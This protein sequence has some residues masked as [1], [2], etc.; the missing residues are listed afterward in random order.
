M[1]KRLFYLLFR[2]AQQEAFIEERIQHTFKKASI[3][4]FDSEYVISPLQKL[5]A[6]DLGSTS[7]NA[8][9][10]PLTCCITHCMHREYR[11]EPTRKRLD[12]IFYS[13]EQLA[14]QV[15]IDNHIIKG[16]QQTI[17]IE[18]SKRKKGKRLNLVGKE[19]SGPQFFTPARVKAALEY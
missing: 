6:M 17:Q 14:A 3:Q 19:D 11:L 7:L 13:H 2:A 15:S 12:L 18:K 1:T 10:T 8:A 9:K 4:P 16:L 5:V